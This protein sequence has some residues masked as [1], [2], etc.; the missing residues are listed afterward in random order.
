MIWK[1]RSIAPDGG[2]GR[3]CSDWA[4]ICVKPK[5]GITTFRRTLL[6]GRSR[7]RTN[8]TCTTFGTALVALC[9]LAPI[10]VHAAGLTLGDQTAGSGQ[11]VLAA[12]SFFS[13]GQTV[14][15]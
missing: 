14:S 13:E 1:D 3:I 2:A 12:G 15:G 9:T 8:S 10:T 6:S 11:T 4:H 5:R 7:G